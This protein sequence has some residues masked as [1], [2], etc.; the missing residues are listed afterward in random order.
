M[1]IGRFD[2]FNHYYSGIALF[3]LK[4]NYVCLPS[5]GVHHFHFRHD[6]DNGKSGDNR[7]FIFA[8]FAFFTMMAKTM[9]KTKAAEKNFCH[10]RHDGEN[11][12]KTFTIFTM[13]KMKNV[14]TSGEWR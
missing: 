10:F 3:T 9:I 4:I 12:E 7:D 13:A 11:G 1:E 5:Q 8:T 2:P 14:L 6:D